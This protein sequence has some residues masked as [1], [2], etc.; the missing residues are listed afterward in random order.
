MQFS[1]ESPDSV[2]KAESPPASQPK[3][4]P[5]LPPHHHPLGCTFLEG[6]VVLATLVKN[7]ILLSF[8]IAFPFSLPLLPP[9]SV[10]F[11]M[12]DSNF[13]YGKTLFNWKVGWI[14]TFF[15]R[16]ALSTQTLNGPKEHTAQVRQ[17]VLYS[18]VS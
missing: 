1:A 15:S 9:L 10:S 7:N 12:S 2:L 14:K 3:Y 13:F 11:G 5:P 18:R 17:L 8:Y 6:A 16:L 4:T